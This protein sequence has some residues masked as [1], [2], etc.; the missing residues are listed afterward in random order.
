MNKRV[1]GLFI[2]LFLAGCA[3]DEPDYAVPPAVNIVTELKPVDTTLVNESYE[4][5]EAKEEDALETFASKDGL[6]VIEKKPSYYEV[7]LYHDKGDPYS[8]GCAYGEV[9]K[10]MGTDYAEILEPYLY[11]NIDSAFPNLDGEYTPV[12]D[13]INILKTQIPTEYLQ[14]LEGFAQTLSGGL[15]GMDSDG[16]LSYEELLLASMVPDCLRGTNC[17]AL[18]VWGE[19]TASGER[20]VSR[21]LDWPMGSTNQMCSAQAVTHFVEGEGKNSY[22]SFSVLGM[23][24][25]LSGLNDKLVFAAMLDAGSG[26]EYVCEGKKCYSFELRHALETMDTARGLGEYMLEESKNFTFSHNIIVTDK[27]DCFVAEDCVDDTEDSTGQSMLRDKD[28]PLLDGISWDNPDSLCVVNAFQSEGADDFLT[29]NGGNYIRF[30]KYNKWVGEKDRLSVA[31]VKSIV[32]RESTERDSGW[33]EIYSYL[34]YHVIIFDYAT[35]ELDVAFTG[36]EGVKDHP[37]FTRVL[38]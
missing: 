25:V 30:C 4:G 1:I 15:K 26:N 27:D 32:T 17:S 12:I 10:D 34:T 36:P 16:K 18:S 22:T 24:D 19:K 33:H 5:A 28:T 11:E 7:W 2:L 13:R 21:T 35:G 6:C 23:L 29:A 20:I 38:Y 14:E 3:S 31:D 37:V 8:V 9:I